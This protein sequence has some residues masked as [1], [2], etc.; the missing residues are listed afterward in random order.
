MIIIGSACSTS[1]KTHYPTKRKKKDCD[2]C[3]KW[4]FNDKRIEKSY[5]A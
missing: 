5:M 4:S 1:R 2:N 3:S